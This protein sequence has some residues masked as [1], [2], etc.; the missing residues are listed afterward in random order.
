MPVGYR[1][2]PGPRPEDELENEKKDEKVEKTDQVKQLDAH[3]NWW[4]VNNEVLN[5]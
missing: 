4:A 3:T 5:A 2:L 1:N